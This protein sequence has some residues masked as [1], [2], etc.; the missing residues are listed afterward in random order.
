MKQ[1]LLKNKKQTI[2]ICTMFLVFLCILLII[3]YNNAPDEHARY[4]VAEYM[5]NHNQLPIATD[6]EVRIPLW[7]TTYAT[8]PFLAYMF[9]AFAMKVMSLFSGDVNNLLYAARIVNAVIS[10][11]TIYFVMK[12]AKEIFKKEERWLFITLCCCLPCFIFV[13][14]YVNNDAIAI[15]STSII[16]YAW[17]IGMKTK[18]EKRSCIYLVVG[19][20]ICM[21]S[22]KNAYGYLL[23]TILIYLYELYCA[24][25]EQR[26]LDM[27]KKGGIIVV[28][29]AILGGWS[30]FRNYLIYDGDFMGSNLSYYLG[31]TYGID[32]LKPSMRITPSNSG[33]SFSYMLHD[34]DWLYTSYRSFI[35]VFGYMSVW[36]PDFYYDL[37]NIIFIFGIIGLCFYL[38]N[39]SSISIRK[40]VFYLAMILCAIIPVCLSAYYSYTEGFQAQGR[41]CLPMLIPLMFFVSKGISKIL[42]YIKPNLR[43]MFYSSFAILMVCLSFYMVI[44]TFASTYL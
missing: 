28:C 15:M 36:L 27:L 35:G 7:G 33:Y 44:N 40:F 6:P 34:M 30:Y 43:T 14:C 11:I 20:S 1:I 41:Y 23:V 13:T 21:Q 10:C 29:V 3:P 24:W 25:K 26:L 2:F 39:L 38:S 4:I 8:S 16:I 22:Y 18:W 12:I 42:S 19:L 31:E 9:S 5:Y 37:Y 32:S 17:I